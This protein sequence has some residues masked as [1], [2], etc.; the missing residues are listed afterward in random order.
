MAEYKKRKAAEK[1]PPKQVDKRLKKQRIKAEIGFPKV[2]PGEM[3]K[4]AKAGTSQAKKK[5]TTANT[6]AA[7]TKKD[8]MS[9]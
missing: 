2:R 5:E 1:T 4:K 3:K 6:H 8:S 7:N 9:V